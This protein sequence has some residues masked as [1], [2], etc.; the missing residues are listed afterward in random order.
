MSL[1]WWKR[2]AKAGGSSEQFESV[3]LISVP[4]YGGA[5]NTLFCDRSRYRISVSSCEISGRQFGVSDSFCR[6]SVPCSDCFRIFSVNCY[7]SNGL[8]A[9]FI[10]AQRIR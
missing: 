3:R 4:K 7:F 5:L 10:S 2:C 9:S 1:R 6:F 8:E